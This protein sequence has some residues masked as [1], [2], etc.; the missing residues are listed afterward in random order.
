MT[1]YI[2]GYIVKIEANREVLTTLLEKITQNRG[3]P[4]DAWEVTALLEVYGLRDIDAKKDYGYDDLFDMGEDVYELIDIYTYPQKIVNLE[5]NP[6]RVKRI[7][8]HYL[9]GLAFA[10]PMIVQIMFTLVLGY[11]IWSS[12]DYD[13][14]I[15]TVIAVGTFL[16]LVVTG[17]TAQAIGRKGLYYIK[18]E[19]Y[20]LASASV[21]LLYFL[22]IVGIFILALVLYLVQLFFH[23]FIDYYYLV[24]IIFYILLSVFFLNASV[25]YMH[26]QHGR[27]LMH[28]VLGMILVYLMHS[29]FKIAL[30]DAQFYTILILDFEMTILIFLKLRKLRKQSESAEGFMLP[31]A[32]IMFYSLIPFYTYGFLYFLF[33]ILDRVV[34]WSV[35][36]IAKPYFIWF[37]VPYELGLDWALIALVLLMGF[38]EAGIYEFMYIMNSIIAKYK[39]NESQKF[40]DE[41]SRFMKKFLIIYFVSSFFIMILVHY[42]IKIGVF[43]FEIPQLK[44]FLQ[45]P[46]PFVFWIAA[47]SYIFLVGSLLNILF[48]FAMSRQKTPVK[49]ILI[50]TIINLI[51]GT[52]LSRVVSYEYA[53]F[54]LLFGTVFLYFSTYNYTRKA[55]N[56]LDYYYYSAF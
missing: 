24:M 28:V 10:M 5:P 13:L 21:K 14:E 22:G 45:E 18:L 39:F 29:V 11:A 4:T 19:E 17:P 53:V 31:K 2:K 34:A 3:K 20:A 49:Y 15:A 43:I 40:A 42:L 32:S 7:T 27:L 23:V 30:P 8:K 41:V 55:I 12:L 9:E 46:T 25:Y 36:D 33:L 6:N 38:T 47:V 26:E 51:I 44:I 48:L 52:I 1:P 37:N 35:P 54:G 16:A 56:K 50:S